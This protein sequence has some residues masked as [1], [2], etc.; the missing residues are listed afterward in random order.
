MEVTYEKNTDSK[1]VQFKKGKVDRTEEVN[2]WFFLDYDKENNVL[3]AEILD[4]SMH[5]V[6]L[7]VVNNV[8]IEFLLEQESEPTEKI[9]KKILSEEVAQKPSDDVLQKTLVASY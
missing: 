1:Y 4:A 5:Q 2:D 9:R 3:G 6:N 8:L 7:A